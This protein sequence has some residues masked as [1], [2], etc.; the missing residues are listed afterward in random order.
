MCTTLRVSLTLS[1]NFL[2]V[3]LKSSTFVK[4]VPQKD[5]SKLGAKHSTLFLIFLEKFC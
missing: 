1:K 4:N 5:A 3:R 2:L